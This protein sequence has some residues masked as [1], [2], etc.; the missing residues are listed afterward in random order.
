MLLFK[1]KVSLFLLFL[2][3]YF[4]FLVFLLIRCCF[5]VCMEKENGR[6]SYE[7]RPSAEPAACSLLFRANHALADSSA[8]GFAVSLTDWTGLC[9]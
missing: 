2:A 4:P 3:F 6:P 5:G 1:R 8:I 7:K 9:Q